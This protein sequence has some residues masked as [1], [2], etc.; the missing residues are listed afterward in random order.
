MVAQWS[1]GPRPLGVDPTVKRNKLLQF[2]VVKILKV[3]HFNSGRFCLIP[4]ANIFNA[5]DVFPIF[6]FRANVA[7]FY[8]PYV[9]AC[10][11][12]QANIFSG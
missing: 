7:H 5:V 2:S 11:C 9:Q 1:R 6:V 3:R 12:T 10:V 4:T 8:D